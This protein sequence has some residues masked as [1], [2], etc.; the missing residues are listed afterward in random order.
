MKLPGGGVV[1]SANLTPDADT[2]IGTWTEQQF[3]DKFKA[4]DGA[5]ASFAQRRRTA[6]EHVDAV[7]CLR[8]HD[9]RGSRRDL[10]LPADASSRSSIAFRNTTDHG[11][12]ATAAGS[13]RPAAST[14]RSKYHHA[15]AGVASRLQ[16]P[17]VRTRVG[18]RDR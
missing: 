3:V 12:G 18:N 4:F 6:R 17:I 8:R 14:A 13:R 9:A 16:S 5:A 2:G 11:S 7:V 1:R 10:H 15:Y